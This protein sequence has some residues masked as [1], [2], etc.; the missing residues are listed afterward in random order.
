MTHPGGEAVVVAATPTLR[1][2]MA[3]EVQFARIERKPTP[4]G[5]EDT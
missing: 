3:A 2:L 1:A 4:I 5:E